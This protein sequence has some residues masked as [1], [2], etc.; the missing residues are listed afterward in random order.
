LPSFAAGPHGYS[1]LYAFAEEYKGTDHF[2]Y[3]FG[4][5]PEK[6]VLNKYRGEIFRWTGEPTR[7]SFEPVAHTFTDWL[8]EILNSSATPGTGRPGR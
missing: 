2:I 4:R 1:S 3:V 8:A 7:E 6:Y 5:D